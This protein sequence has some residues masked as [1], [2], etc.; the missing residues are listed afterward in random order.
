MAETKIEWCDYTFNPWEGCQRVSPGCLNCYAEAR[1]RRLHAG[2][3]WGPGTPR[4]EHSDA[5]W[6]APYKWNLLAKAA[7][8]RRRVFCGSLCDIFEQPTDPA[9]AELL[10]VIRADVGTMIQN[11]PEL[12][13]LLLTKR[14][15]NWESAFSALGFHYMMPENVWVGVTAEDQKR[16]DER[17]PVLLQIP[18]AVRFVSAEPL[19]E[20]VDFT[21][22]LWPNKGGHRVDVLRRGYW[23]AEG[24]RYGGPSAELGAPRGWFTNHSDMASVDWVIVGGESGPGARPFD[25]GWARRTAEEC[26]AAE[27]ACFIK[28]MGSK[29]HFDEYTGDPWKIT[30]KKGGNW[31]EWPA[32]LRVRE[33][34]VRTAEPRTGQ[35]PPPDPRP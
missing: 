9:A 26:K 28:Q 29:P 25:V 34:P 7:G 15:E 2:A 30:D 31:H 8:V 10:D 20:Y 24:W 11:T 32:E 33:L 18:A 3:H 23:N 17:I 1:D 12:D 4:I 27:V 21:S 22:V 5:Y 13:W 6:R 19:L 35:A 14:P 16:A